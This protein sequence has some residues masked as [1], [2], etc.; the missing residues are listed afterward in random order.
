MN[1]R[2][3]VGPALRLWWCS[4]AALSAALVVD[5]DVTEN[6]TLAFVTVALCAALIVY[7]GAVCGSSTRG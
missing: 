1:G 2:G 6:R 4:G 3:T 5:A 7:A